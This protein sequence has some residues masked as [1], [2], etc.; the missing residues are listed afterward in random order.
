MAHSIAVRIQKVRSANGRRIVGYEALFGDL[1][2]RAES[3]QGALDLLQSKLI[4]RSLY[5]DSNPIVETYGGYT[6]VCWQGLEGFCHRIAGHTSYT[7]G[8]SSMEEAQARG[9][10]HIAQLLMDDGMNRETVRDIAADKSLFDS[11]FPPG[12]VGAPIGQPESELEWLRR[13]GAH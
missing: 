12:H 9:C 4:F 2:A 8:H 1:T 6:L 5:K 3:E 10:D 13:T 7:S 11:L